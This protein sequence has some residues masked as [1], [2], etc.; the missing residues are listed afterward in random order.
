MQQLGLQQSLS[1][2]GEY[3][4]SDLSEGLFNSLLKDV[5]MHLEDHVAETN[6]SGISQTASGKENEFSSSSRESLPQFEKEQH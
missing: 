1:S 2:N 4:S 6:W 3:D 5:E